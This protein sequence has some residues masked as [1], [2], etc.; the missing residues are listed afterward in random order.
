MEFLRFGS[1]IPG[2]YWGCCAVC[3]IQ[4]FKQAPTDK[5]GVQIVSGDGGTPIGDRF[6]GDTWE[7]IFRK[8]LRI[9]TFSVA[10]MPNHVFFA[11]LTEWQINNSPGK[12][13]LKILKEEGFEFVRTTDNSVYNGPTLRSKAPSSPH[14]NY[15]FALYRNIG[16]GYVEDTFTPPKAWTDLPSVT[17]EAYTYTLAGMEAKKTTPKAVQESLAGIQK[18]IW[19]RTGPVTFRSEA[20]L[21]EAGVPVHYAGIRPQTKG[22]LREQRKAA[23]EQQIRS[24]QSLLDSMNKKAE[25]KKTKEDQAKMAEASKAVKAKA[26]TAA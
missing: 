16:N 21:D 2:A 3:I 4:D 15:I 1:N 26:K 18:E 25:A 12:D 10:D 8:R 7:D 11:I 6:I 19:D 17:N 13:W 9:G 23:L 5:A 20:Q 14:K 24:S 22:Q